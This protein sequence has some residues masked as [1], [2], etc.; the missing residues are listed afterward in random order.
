M[1]LKHPCALDK[2]KIYA[3]RKLILPNKYRK[4]FFLNIN[5]SNKKMLYC[6][7]CLIVFFNSELFQL[8]F[9]NFE[10]WLFKFQIKLF[11]LIL[12]NQLKISNQEKSC[13]HVFK[14]RQIE[15]TRV[16]KWGVLSKIF[17][18]ICEKKKFTKNVSQILVQSLE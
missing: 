14:R 15:P 2:N 5:F 16:F 18:N 17:K 6:W 13:F 4:F 1:R 9:K 10:I 12:K 8:I 7:W 11:V 3:I